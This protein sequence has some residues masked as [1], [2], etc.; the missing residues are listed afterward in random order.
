MRRYRPETDMANGCGPTALAA[1]L[2]GTAQDYVKYASV[3]E[4]G[5]WKGHFLGMHITEQEA[6]IRAAGFHFSTTFFTRGRGRRLLSALLPTDKRGIAYVC[7]GHT[8][9]SIAFDGKMVFDSNSDGRWMW[10]YDHK[11]WGYATCYCITIIEETAH[12]RPIIVEEP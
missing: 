12:R 5:R 6:A 9:H 2:G 4:H 1:T 11:R 3:A 8:A 10:V 7:R